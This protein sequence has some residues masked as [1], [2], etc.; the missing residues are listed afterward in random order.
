MLPIAV[1]FSGVPAVHGDTEA[2]FQLKRGH[3]SPAQL[4]RD[5]EP[6]PVTGESRPTS[7]PHCTH[8][9]DVVSIKGCK[10]ST[11]AHILGL[12]LTAQPAIHQALVYKT[13]KMKA[14]CHFALQS[15]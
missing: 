10:V 5:T 7:D 8:F 2:V 12:P 1:A 14:R 3:A 4:W 6:H 11:G 15:P 13:L 9:A